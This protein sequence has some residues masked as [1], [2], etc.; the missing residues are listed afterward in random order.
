MTQTSRYLILGVGVAVG[1]L[2]GAGQAAAQ[3]KEARGTVTAVA[4]RSVTVKAGAQELTFFADRETHIEVRSTEK[5]LQQAKAGSPAPRV[6]DF[7]KPGY[8]VLVRYREENGRNHA[9]DIERVG[10][11][12]A[13]GGSIS[14]PERIASGKVKAITASQVT[15]DDNGRE[16]V[17][18]ITG[19]TGVMKKG[20]TKAT[21]AAGGSTPITTFIHAGD[22]VSISYREAAGRATATE[23]RVRISNP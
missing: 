19:D 15:I 11:T 22:T 2:A 1:V 14:E 10:S 16:A 21:K 9:L 6:S 13:G 20:A 12:G 5:A 18:G 4:E 17:F 8:T 7:L 3:T 23:V